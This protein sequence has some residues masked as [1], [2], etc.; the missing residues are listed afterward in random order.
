MDRL[1]PRVSSLQGSRSQ[2]T[3]RS[4]CCCPSVGL[5]FPGEA[6][7][8]LTRHATGNKLKYTSAVG[9]IQATCPI[10]PIAHRSSITAHPHR[11]HVTTPHSVS[12]NQ[13]RKISIRRILSGCGKLKVTLSM[14]ALHLVFRVP[15]Q[16]LSP[17][18][19]PPCHL[20]FPELIPGLIYLSFRLYQITSTVSTHLR[21]LRIF[22]VCQS[23]HSYNRLPVS[24]FLRVQCLWLQ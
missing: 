12:I 23:F 13:S 6:A 8:K 16:H 22:P 18:L 14:K 20:F 11:P 3:R 19:R 24:K 7:Q 5:S 21:T 1:L 15:L 4:R 10:P 2:V 9:D 17:H